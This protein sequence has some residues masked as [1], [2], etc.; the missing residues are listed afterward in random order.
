MN[1]EAVKLYRM[2]TGEHECPWGL[3]ALSLLNE[4]GVDFEDVKLASQD[5]V[6]A[7]K[8]KYEVATTPQIFFGDDRIGGYTDLAAYFEVEAEAAEYSY[9]P[10]AAVFSTAG[11]M[12][13]A[14]SLGVAGFMGIS[15]SMLA[16]LKLMDLDSFS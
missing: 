2:S 10:V 13:I 6:A 16:S 15:L 4:K 11:L 1:A 7:F 9:I 5:E 14:A 3:K 8:Q 12:A